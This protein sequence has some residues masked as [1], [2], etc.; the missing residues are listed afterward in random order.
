MN[1][2]RS[3]TLIIAILCAWPAL[4]QAQGA[5]AEWAALNQEIMDLYWQGN[6]A[7]AAVVAQQ[8]LTLAETQA[9][10]NHPDVVTSLEK[11]ASLYR[12]TQRPA[13]ARELEQRAAQIRAMGR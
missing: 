12:A 11:L 7:Q 6:Y 3:W 9:G 13:E 8:A 1:H 4:T 10:P 2:F 5:G